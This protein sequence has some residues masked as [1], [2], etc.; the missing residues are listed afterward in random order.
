M[1]EKIYFESVV[2]AVVV[3]FIQSQKWPAFRSYPAVKAFVNNSGSH[4]FIYTDNEERF[5]ELAQWTQNS[6]QKVKITQ[7]RKPETP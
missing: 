1:K 3:D 5:V 2:V 4:N 7:K 6:M